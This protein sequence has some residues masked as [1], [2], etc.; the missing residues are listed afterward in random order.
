MRSGHTAGRF[1]HGVLVSLGL[2]F[3]AVAA[4]A[5]NVGYSPGTFS[6]DPT[7][8]ANYEIPINVPPGVHSM[9]PKLALLYNSRAGNGQLGVGWSLSG[10]SAITRCPQTLDQDNNIHIP[11]L[12]LFL[13]Q[14]HRPL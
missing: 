11:D 2:W 9:Q 10:L 14:I 5:A 12:C 7:G 13:D 3:T 6:V 1:A 4:Q 8:A